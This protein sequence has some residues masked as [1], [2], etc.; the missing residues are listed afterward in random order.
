MNDQQQ[1]PRDEAATRIEA[2]LR[3]MADA[4]ATQG[5]AIQTLQDRVESLYQNSLDV[6][7]KLSATGT[8]LKGLGQRV[9]ELVEA[10]NAIVQMVDQQRVLIERI[11]VAEARRKGV[12]N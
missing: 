3:Q 10:N 8:S 4:I 5:K 6:D 9:A 7:I 12:L 2:M 1:D 11:T